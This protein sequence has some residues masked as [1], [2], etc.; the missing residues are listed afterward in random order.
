MALARIDW[1]KEYA[2]WDVTAASLERA[3]APSRLLDVLAAFLPRGAGA[4]VL[5]LGCAPGRWLAWAEAALGIRPVGIELDPAGARLTHSLYPRIAIV[6]ADAARLPIRDGALSAVYAL[7]VIEH[8]DD[9]GPVIAEARRVLQAGGIAVW[10]VPNLIPGSVCRWHW[11][12]FL[13]GALA[14]HR[15]FTL[16]ELR[17]V[18]RRE[19]FAVVH[20]EYNG[21]YIPHCQ[22]LMG[23]LPLRRVLRKLERPR[24]AASV[25]V[26]ARAG[27]G[28]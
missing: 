26:V 19:G 17:G 25:V 9:P 23:R 6:R 28:S 3:Y 24:L 7:G 5:E 4:A 15:V 11:G 2:T 27:G 18:V 12:T 21:L 14:T 20:A 16:D 8:F 1:A 13:R 10:S 22:R